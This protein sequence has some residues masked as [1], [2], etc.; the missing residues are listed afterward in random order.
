MALED[1]WALAECLDGAGALE[2]R[3]VAYQECR[4]ERVCRVVE[5]ANGNAWKYHLSF[6]PLRWA[7]HT[8][9]RVGG[10]VAPGRLMRQFDW[11]Y[12]YDVTKAALR[13]PA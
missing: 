7:A 5:T 10:A 11:I 9:L 6:S 1:C 3:L 4:R 8:A 13:R 12:G 2:D